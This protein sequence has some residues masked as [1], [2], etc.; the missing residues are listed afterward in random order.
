MIVRGAAHAVMVDRA[1]AFNEA[2]L[3]FLDR[4]RAATEDADAS[5]A[6]L[7]S[8]NLPLASA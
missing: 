4:H 1:P 8:V 5:P 6:E 3:S 7:A 2:V